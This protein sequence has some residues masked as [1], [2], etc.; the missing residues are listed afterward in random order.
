MR[1]NSFPNKNP[2]K[3]P[4]KHLTGGGGVGSG[5]NFNQ[6]IDVSSDEEERNV[7][8]KGYKQDFNFMKTTLKIENNEVENNDEVF[9]YQEKVDDVLEMNDELLAMHMNILKVPKLIFPILL[10]FC[11]K[12]LFACRRRLTCTRR[13]RTAT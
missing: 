11:R 2:F 12:T 3:Q 5:N 9:Q 10:I 8:R 7:R 4:N 6:R 1:Q 13:S